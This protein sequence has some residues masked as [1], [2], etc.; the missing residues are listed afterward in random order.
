MTPS[1]RT[2]AASLFEVRGGAPRALRS[3]RGCCSVYAPTVAGDGDH[4]AACPAPGQA[5]IAS[6]A[7]TPPACGPRPCRLLRHACHAGVPLG[8]AHRVPAG[9]HQVRHGGAGLPQAASRCQLRSRS[10]AAAEREAHAWDCALAFGAACR[11]LAVPCWTDAACCP[12]FPPAAAV[13]CPCLGTTWTKT[14]TPASTSAMP[15]RAACPACASWPT[16]SRRARCWAAT[17]PPA[18]SHPLPPRALPAGP[19]RP[20]PDP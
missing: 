3:R 10:R 16:L 12:P 4:A 20:P 8:E 6:P 15:G 2:F 18:S 17:L 5:A 1:N 7:S 19:T 9:A 14:P 11:P 13:T